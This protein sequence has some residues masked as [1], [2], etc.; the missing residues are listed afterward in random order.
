MVEIPK[1]I[2]HTELSIIKVINNESNVLS[3]EIL[4][5]EG[6]SSSKG[7]HLLNYLCAL[8]GTN[9][10]EIGSW[11]GSTA[12]SA[13]Y[14]NKIAN[15]TLVENWKLGC[16]GVRDVLFANFNNI[17]GYDPNIIEE[18]CFSFNPLEKGIKDINVY[19]YDGEHEETDQYQ[20]LTHYYDSLSDTF[21]YIV[22]DTNYPPVLIGTLKAIVDKNLKIH[23]QW[24]LQATHNGDAHNFW[25]GMYVG[26][27]SKQ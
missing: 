13:L 9:Y 21:I 11:K 25:N 8:E 3:K 27:L 22:D 18:D 23:K 2:E 5:L 15:Y 19:F 1:L 7:R 10:L 4:E 6:M 14:Q 17:L 12:V 16:E 24:T 20:A 26:I